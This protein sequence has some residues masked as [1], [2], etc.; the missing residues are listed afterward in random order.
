MAIFDTPEIFLQ[1]QTPSSTCNHVS[2]ANSRNSH[3]QF[4]PLF[5]SLPL[6]SLQSLEVEQKVKL[7]RLSVRYRLENSADDAG[8]EDAPWVM[9]ECTLNGRWESRVARAGVSPLPL[10]TA[11]D[12]NQ[13]GVQSPPSVWLPLHRSPCWPSDTGLTWGTSSLSS[14]VLSF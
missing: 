8:G 10:Q 13:S 1:N 5:T 9:G 3:L 14:S 7:K 11:A 12:T 6:T 4:S 2:P